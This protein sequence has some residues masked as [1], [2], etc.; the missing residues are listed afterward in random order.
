M[1]APSLL[2]LTLS[3]WIGM[4][5]ISLIIS[6]GDGTAACLGRGAGVGA[7]TGQVESRMIDHA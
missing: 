7:V 1:H 5:S 4:G 3:A 6:I 2:Q